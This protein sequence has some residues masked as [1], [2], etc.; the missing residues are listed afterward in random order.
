MAE[1]ELNQS[2]DSCL[3]SKHLSRKLK[4]VA[5]LD[6]DPKFD[7]YFEEA[8]SQAQRN[9]VF[10]AIMYFVARPPRSTS[11]PYATVAAALNEHYSLAANMT[12][13]APLE[14]R[15][16]SGKQIGNLFSFLESHKAV[17]W[18][19]GASEIRFWCR[20]EGSEFYPVRF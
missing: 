16:A 10:Q 5:G 19:V 8:T 9:A 3:T 11:P 17:I 18:G 14:I 7:L 2:T 15:F 20:I 12:Q 4:Q 13:D 1:L 6:S